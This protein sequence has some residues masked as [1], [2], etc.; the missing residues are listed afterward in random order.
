M[1]TSSAE[2][3]FIFVSIC[4]SIMTRRPTFRSDFV[5]GLSALMYFVAFSNMMTTGL[6]VVSLIVNVSLPMAV[7]VPIMGSPCEYSSPTKATTTTKQK[8]ADFSICF[9]L[10]MMFLAIFYRQVLACQES[11]HSLFF[12]Q[13]HR[14]LRVHFL[15][16]GKFFIGE[17][18][19]V[20]NEMNQ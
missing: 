5:T 16:P 3:I 15:H 1:T 17:G 18:R 11:S 7:T 13:F 20:P 9:S 4:A 8:A 2:Y 6:L 19:Q 12:F 14:T 10:M